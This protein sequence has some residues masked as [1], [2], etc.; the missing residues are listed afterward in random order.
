MDPA[1]KKLSVYPL[2]NHPMECNIYLIKG[3]RNILVDTGLGNSVERLI[4]HID[5][6]LGVTKV[7]AIILTHKHID[8]TGGA[9]GFHKATGA[10][11][12]IH[13]IESEAV[14]TGDPAST[15]AAMFGVK[16]EP[17]DV[18]IFEEG[19]EVDLGGGDAL[20]VLH[21]PGHSEGSVCLWHEP[22]SS[23]FSGDTVFTNGGV[24][25]W[26]LPGGDFKQLHNS[27]KRLSGLDVVDIYPGH[28]SWDLG[29]GRQHIELGLMSLSMY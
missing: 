3:E 17:V 24:G 29:D 25:R 16:A 22:T 11:L 18:E 20:K 9:S 21:T 7:H 5:E 15:G 13:K 27:L 26:D 8:H 14:S 2:R 1:K 10:P 4:R 28:M 23:L 12:Y 19:G 6:E